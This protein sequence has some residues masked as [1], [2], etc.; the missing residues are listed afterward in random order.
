MAFSELE[1]LKFTQMY[2]FL[3]SYLSFQDQF[4]KFLVIEQGES[5]W[6]AS[7]A[8]WELNSL[9]HLHPCSVCGLKTELLTS[10]IL[11]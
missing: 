8:V 9:E 7:L 11:F 4:R 10:K 2:V 6:N 3:G 5:C 1:G